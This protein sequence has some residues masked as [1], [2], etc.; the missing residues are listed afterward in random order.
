MQ[1]QTAN[2]TNAE[3]IYGNFLNVQGAT[4]TTGYPVAFTTTAASLDGNQAVLPATG[5]RHSFAGIAQADVAD[6]T[7][8]RFQCWGYHAS[9][10]IFACGTSVTDNV[11]DVLGPNAGSVGVNST[12]RVDILTPV[13]AMEAIGA[14]VNSPGGYAKCFIKSM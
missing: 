1:I 2:Y 10:F 6:N 7:V 3:V 4:I 5:Q 11:D 14:D 8:G 9:V 13:I 12:G